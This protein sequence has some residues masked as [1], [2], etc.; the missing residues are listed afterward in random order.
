MI[1]GKDNYLHKNRGKFLLGYEMGDSYVQISYMKIGEQKPQTLS[2]VAGA[3]DYKIP[4]VLFRAEDS[5]LWYFGKEA[6]E[7]QKEKQGHEITNLLEL[8][9]R[10]K[11]YAI[12]EDVYDT[13]ALLAL[14][15]KRSFSLLSMTAPREYIAACNFTLQEA[16]KEQIE[17]L[18]K[19]RDFLQLK[20]ID[21][22][23]MGKEESFF[24]YNLHTDP[25]LWKNKVYLYEMEEDHFISYC[26]ELNRNTSPVVTMIHKKEYPLRENNNLLTKEEKDEW[27]L[28]I[29][30]EDMEN[31]I[32]STV[33]LIGEGFLGEWYQQSVRYLCQKRRVFL[34]NNLYSS[35]ACYGLSHL[36]MPRE[37][38][39]GY[40]YLG[41]DKLLTN[42][43]LLVLHRGKEIYLPVLDG[44][45]SWYQIKKEWDF[46]MEE[47]NR[48]KFR[49]TP[50]DGKNVIYREVLLQGLSLKKG[51]YCRIHM[52]VTME[53]K[54]R[55]LV[56]IWEK[57]FG[58]FYPS[59]NQ[60]WEEIIVL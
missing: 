31:T 5:G 32:V 25:Q 14:F 27:F 38:L 30:K 51:V 10:Q 6:K 36:L 28:S 37:E 2:L 56:K 20:H 47:E 19:M 59:K 58:E 13:T 50:L 54:N 16:K 49:I 53:A 39:R 41:D 29:L 34:G 48:L 44:G 26:L 40:I 15:V 24:Y 35:G 23:I 9:C 17:V 11:E 46:L 55:M 8:A 7:K 4:F 18:Q 12:G 52:E 22:Y 57:G 3:Q 45:S 21:V 33:Y 43:G 60:Y 42:V 1:F